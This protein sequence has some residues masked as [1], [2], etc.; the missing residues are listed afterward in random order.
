MLLLC[1]IVLPSKTL[2]CNFN[3][4]TGNGYLGS[5]VIKRALKLGLSVISINR[6][7]K[8]A[9]FEHDGDESRIEWRSGDIMKESEWQDDLVDCDAAVSCVGAFGSY[10]VMLY[11]FIDIFVKKKFTFPSRCECVY[12]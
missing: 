10:E 4:L 5:Q 3:L 7:G 1:L 6:S 9:G 12:L 11:Q 8:P 2:N